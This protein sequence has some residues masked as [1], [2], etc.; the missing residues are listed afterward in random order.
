[1]P[2]RTTGDPGPE[3]RRL[4]FEV[5]GRT[6]SAEIG[7]PQLFELAGLL[8]PYYETP[9]PDAGFSASPDV[10]VE[11]APHGYLVAPCD[12]SPVVCGTE[13][14]T[15]ATL[16]FALTRA[17]IASLGEYIHLHA[18]GAVVEGQ[19]VLALGRSG[20]GKS[21]LAVSWL[22]RG[23][24]TLGDDIVF[25]D[26]A[27]RAKPFKRL[28]KV[29]PLALQVLDIDPATTLQWDPDWPE[30]WFDPDDGAGWAEEAPVAI[31]ACVRYDPRASL[32]LTP[33]S[34]TEAL[35]FVVH[36]IMDTGKRAGDCF[37]TL[38]RLV[39]DSRAFSVVYPSAHEAA[40]VLCSLTK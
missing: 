39:E 9:K 1:M 5:G 25:L 4:Y 7:D 33:M 10:C 24:K 12:E 28:F 29:T 31:V 40:E 36:S 34:T 15:L 14:E 21:S 3:G 35:N 2:A 18:S 11:K 16:E 8:F 17:M 20:A 38:A 23:Y 6:L 37:D 26:A 13:M 27:A 30:A 19:A 32:S 22:S